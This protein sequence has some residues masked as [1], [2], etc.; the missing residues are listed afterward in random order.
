M[1]VTL[2]RDAALKAISRVHGAVS[3]SQT[4]VLMNMLLVADTDGLTLTATNLDLQI[5]ER[6]ACRVAEPGAITLPANA[7]NDIV[8]NSPPGGEIEISV[9]AEASRATIRC[10][11][12]RFQQPTLP[13]GD[14]A[15]FSDDGL[16]AGGVL[17]AEVLKRA[18][19]KVRFAMSSEE[20]RR[21][22]NGVYLHPATVEKGRG[23]RM[24][25]T[26]GHRLALHEIASDAELI[27]AEDG[28][29]SGVIIARGTADELARLLTDAGK[30]D[31]VRVR[32]SSNKVQFSMGEWEMTSRLMDGS[33]PDYD[34]VIPRANSA[35]I[36]F[37]A[38]LLEAAIKR[39]SIVATGKG[40]RMGLSVSEGRATLQARNVEAGQLDEEMDVEGAD[41]P[42]AVKLNAKYVADQLAR[43]DGDFMEMRFGETDKVAILVSD[44][45]DARSTFVLMP[46]LTGDEA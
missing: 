31:E 40:R 2:E 12:S 36:R 28:E 37:D 38:V 1:K 9:G 17:S 15:R 7:L 44:P 4:P 16:P 30:G 29:I 26:D 8:R 5:A 24:V 27:A 20:T 3:K 6:V 45:L 13:A 46:Q 35:A 14:F 21:Y 34:R 42:Y 25:A 10:G 11:R 22:L 18:L 19:D 23:W 33:Y 43:I 32:A 41:L 39:V